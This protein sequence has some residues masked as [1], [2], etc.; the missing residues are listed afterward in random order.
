MEFLCILILYDYAKV[1]ALITFALFKYIFIFIVFHLLYKQAQLSSAAGLTEAD[2]ERYFQFAAVWAF[3][4]M[5]EAE[6]RENFNI[7]WRETIGLQVQF[8][9][10]GQVNDLFSDTFLI[11]YHK[12]LVVLKLRPNCLQYLSTAMD[13]K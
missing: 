2:V 13:R 8:P 9:V 5:L 7:F 11:T 4:G 10:D 6:F 12:C 1:F 3:G